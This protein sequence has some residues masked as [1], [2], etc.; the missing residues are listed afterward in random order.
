ASLMQPWLLRRLSAAGLPVVPFVSG[1]D[2]ELVA[3]FVHEAEGPCRARRLR[4]R[5]RDEREADLAF[6]KEHHGDFDRFPYI[7]RRSVGLLSEA[8]VVGGVCV[9]GRQAHRW[10][11]ASE[12]PDG[13]AA[14]AVHAAALAGLPMC[15]VGVEVDGAG[16]RWVVDVG[17]DGEP[18]ALPDE[19]TDAV[20]TRLADALLELGEEGAPLPGPRSPH[21]PQGTAQPKRIGISGR[22]ADAE[23]R[24]VARAVASQGGEPVPIELPLFPSDRAIHEAEGGGRIAREDLASVDAVY[25]RQ[26]G[27][28]SPLPDPE[29]GPLEAAQWDALYDAYARVP[30]DEADNLLFKYSVLHIVGE[31]VPVI[32]PPDGQEVH[33]NK[34]W[35]LFSL[36]ARG[37]PVPPTVA[38]NDPDACAAFVREQGGPEH[39]VVKPLAGIYK[40][41]LLSDIG[42]ERALEAGPVILQRYI[43][44]DTIRTYI[45]EGE[46][47]GA[48]RI[49]HDT[50]TVDSSIGQTGV[51]LVELPRGA[52]SAGWNAAR[53]LGLHWTGMDFQ[54]EHATGRHFILE[55]NASSMFASFSRQTGCD[56]PG[57]IAAAL[58]RASRAT[59]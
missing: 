6:L 31:R 23:A 14:T 32:N 13:V 12:L 55:C 46:L 18:D 40:T 26:T 30:T 10:L 1:N 7:V 54:R 36:A 59:G 41:C 5:A 15:I 29:H 3:R 37:L 25:V 2:L 47:V 39:V 42:L 20:L 58:L 38:G 24:A 53:H 28:A 33:R 57:A 27:V 11:P 35:Q 9:G 17:A 44:G 43:Q 21:R 19:G 45:V 50:S 22:M 16:D 4:E 56:V 52:V 34:V 51:E 8:W 49:V 48:G